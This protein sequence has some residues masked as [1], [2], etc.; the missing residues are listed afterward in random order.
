MDTMDLLL[1]IDQTIPPEKVSGLI[2]VLVK[3]LWKVLIN[4]IKTFVDVT[5]FITGEATK[6]VIAGGLF[7]VKLLWKVL[8]NVMKTFAD[9]TPF[10]TGEARKKVI[11]SGFWKEVL[12]QSMALKESIVAD[13]T[14]TFDITIILFVILGIVLLLLNG[15]LHLVKL[16]LIP[17]VYLSIEQHRKWTALVLTI[18]TV[19]LGI[20]FLKLSPTYHYR[21]NACTAIFCLLPLLFDALWHVSRRTSTPTETKGK[22]MENLHGVR[23][24]QQVLNRI[25]NRLSHTVQLFKSLLSIEESKDVEAKREDRI[26]RNYRERAASGQCVIC[27]DDNPNIATLCCGRAS[28]TFKL[29][30]GLAIRV[31]CRGYLPRY[32]LSAN[33]IR[34]VIATLRRRRG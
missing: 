19:M 15:T 25:V 5:L 8:M 13:H 22:Q 27:Y 34:S 10:I 9:V 32:D 21:I 23:M 29:P 28:V 2:L 3:I 20:H 4:A 16:K 31:V 33:T 30:S 17:Q 1:W 26:T 24:L 14:I 6:E 18:G 12:A 7:L 11:A